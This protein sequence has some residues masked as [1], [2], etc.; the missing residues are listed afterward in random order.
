MSRWITLLSLKSCGRVTDPEKYD[1]SLGAGEPGA[2]VST[3]TSD[4]RYIYVNFHPS[5]TDC[6]D[7]DG[8]RKWTCM[9]TVRSPDEHGRVA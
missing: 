6:F 5:L 3:P 8:N 9:H 1:A 2:S 4:G 7:L